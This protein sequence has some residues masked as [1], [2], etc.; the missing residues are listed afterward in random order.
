MPLYALAISSNQ[1]R[2]HWTR[3]AMQALECLG[4]CQF[5]Q[6]YQIA[7]RQ[8]KGEDY[9]NFAAL[10]QSHLTFDELNQ[11]LKQ[12]EQYAGRVRPSHHIPLDIDIVAWGSCLDDLQPVSMRLPLPFDA[13]K[14]LSEL[15]SVCP[16][17]Y[18]TMPYQIITE[19]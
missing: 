18:N 13:A 14:P 11:Q 8:G 16:A 19:V 2:D 3:Y 17:S 10:L 4:A 9:Y 7:C 5:S 1:Q 15:W 12:L 6:V